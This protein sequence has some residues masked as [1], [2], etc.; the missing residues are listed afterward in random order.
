MA[1]DALSDAATNYSAYDFFIDRQK[2]GIEMQFYL[3]QHLKENG[4]STVEFF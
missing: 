4:F 1:I 2:I 3:N